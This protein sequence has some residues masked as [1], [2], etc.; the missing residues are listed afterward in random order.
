MTKIERLEAS[1]RHSLIE[2]EKLAAAWHTS[3]ETAKS[4][5]A[6]IASTGAI[7]KPAPEY[8]EVPVERWAVVAPS[9]YVEATYPDEERALHAATQPR[10][11]DYA[12]AKLTG[13]VRRE[14]VAPVERSV[15][16]GGILISDGRTGYDKGSV[17]LSE[18]GEV[19]VEFAIHPEFHGC[20]GSLTFTTT[21][22]P[23]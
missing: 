15:T 22:P 23:K 8:A 20:S 7:L 21:D 17:L 12:V 16:V 11:L 2:M 13:T 6:I 1:V 14:K 19:G 18:S 5:R 9:G 4:I 10:Y 3:G